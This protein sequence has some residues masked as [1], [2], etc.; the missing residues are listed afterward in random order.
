MNARQ[1]LIDLLSPKAT[2]KIPKIVRESARAALKHYPQVYELEDLRKA[3]PEILGKCPDS[4]I[5][6]KNTK[7]VRK[8]TH[9]GTLRMKWEDE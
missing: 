9:A 3:C 1:F 5:G 7:K 6:T 4:S 2:P 8:L